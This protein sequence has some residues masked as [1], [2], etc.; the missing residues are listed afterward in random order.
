MLGWQDLTRA[1]CCSPA[2]AAGEKFRVYGPVARSE[3]DEGP[4]PRRFAT[5]RRGILRV[6][7]RAEAHA[8]ARASRERRMVDQTGIEPVTS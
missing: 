4:P 7:C 6:A 2:K 3:T 5:L 1:R 8:S